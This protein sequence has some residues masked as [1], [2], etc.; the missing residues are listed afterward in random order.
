MVQLFYCGP[1]IVKFKATLQF[2]KIKIC[3]FELVRNNPIVTRIVFE[4]ENMLQNKGKYHAAV[5]S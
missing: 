4:H 3:D 5:P 2:H 1:S